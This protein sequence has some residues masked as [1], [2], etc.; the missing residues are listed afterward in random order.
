MTDIKINKISLDRLIKSAEKHTQIIDS[1]MNK[2]TC[3]IGNDLAKEFNRFEK[4]IEL[5]KNKNKLN[6]KIN[7]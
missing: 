7:S 1:L 3:A 2:G 4:S 5:F 6:G